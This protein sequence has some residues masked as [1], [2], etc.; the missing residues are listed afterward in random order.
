M[1]T[2]INPLRSEWTAL[3]ERNIPD[4]PAVDAAVSAI[5]DEVRAKGDAALREMALKFDRCNVG[6]LEVSEAEIAEGCARVSDEVKAAIGLAKENISKFHAAQMPE[7]VDVTTLP[8]VRC[9]QRPVAIDRVG[10]YIPGGQ[11][12]LFSTVL[13][14]ACPAKIAGC[15]EVILCTPQ[16]GDRPI[17]PE[18]LY[19]ASIC[20]IDRIYRVGGAQAIAAMALGTETIGRVDKIFGPGNR[21]VT[22]AKQH[23]SSVVAIDMPAGPSEVLVMADSSANAT[24]VAADLLSQAEHGRD[25]QAILVCDSE[26]TARKVDAEVGRL[27]TRLSRAESVEGSLSHSRLIVFTDSDDMM[28]F[29]N[30]YAPEH[31]IISMR[32]AWTLASKVR[33]AGSV[34]IGNYS[35]ESAGDY[36]SGTNHTLPTAAWARSYSGVNIDSF[37]R[38]ITYQEL[39]RD[40]LGLLAP[41]IVAMAEAEGLDAHALAVKV[42]VDEEAK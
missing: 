40:G 23:L 13:M 11:A 42:R 32:D 27:M 6:A 14:L 1:Q 29:V 38:K 19:A 7:E 31:L 5:I 4:D 16:S 34:F 12:P 9:L 41:T 8:G 2:F 18:I 15:R 35:P 26:E 21:Y 33:A 25:S 17:A 22:K 30:A 24:F 10:L 36:A 3:T 28:D 37:I 39:T 20:G